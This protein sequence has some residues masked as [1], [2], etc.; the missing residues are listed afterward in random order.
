[1][2]RALLVKYPETKLTISFGLAISVIKLKKKSFI[3]AELFSKQWEMSKKKS[4][5]E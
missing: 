4:S 2:E 1:M 5:V 3:K